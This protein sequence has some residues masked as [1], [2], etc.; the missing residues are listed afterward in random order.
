M[1]KDEHEADGTVPRQGGTRLV[2]SMSYGQVRAWIPASGD[3]NF[4][5]WKS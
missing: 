3:R 4:R 1:E 5:L 2:E